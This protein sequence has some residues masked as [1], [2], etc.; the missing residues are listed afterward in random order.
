MIPILVKFCKSKDISL[1]E[2]ASNEVN[3]AI[4]LSNINVISTIVRGIKLREC[5]TIN[6]YDIVFVSISFLTTLTMNM[7]VDIGMIIGINRFVIKIFSKCSI[8]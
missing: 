3:T 8:L 2:I 5:G 1:P 6:R 7:A 4:G